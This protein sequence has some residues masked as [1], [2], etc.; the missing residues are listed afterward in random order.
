ML[1][2]LVLT[3]VL[4]TNAELIFAFLRSL[5]WKLNKQ[6]KKNNTP[7]PVSVGKEV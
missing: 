5:C 3:N 1:L 2:I 7:P 6:P 4:A